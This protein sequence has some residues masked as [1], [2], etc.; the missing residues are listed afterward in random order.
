MNC[1]ALAVLLLTTAIAGIVVQIQMKFIR[2]SQLNFA[3]KR[4]EKKTES[5]AINWY[6]I[7]TSHLYVCILDEKPFVI[8]YHCISLQIII[9]KPEA[10][11]VDCCLVEPAKALSPVTGSHILLCT[12]PWWNTG[13][14]N[15]YLGCVLHCSALQILISLTR[16]AWRNPLV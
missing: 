15:N 10:L 2:A 8:F 16:F 14:E 4:Q 6:A 7:I 3:P 9:V 12:A 13:Y 11:L 1:H 5:Q